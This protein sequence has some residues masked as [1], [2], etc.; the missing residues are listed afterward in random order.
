[1]SSLRQQIADTGRCIERLKRQI[2]QQADFIDCLERNDFDVTRARQALEAMQAELVLQ[3]RYRVS[4][5][6][7]AAFVKE[8][9]EKVS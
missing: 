2:R 1:M 6:Q 7:E 8:P 5:C 3:Q 4:L 9:R